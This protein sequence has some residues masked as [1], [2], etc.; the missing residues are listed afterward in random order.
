MLRIT[1]AEERETSV[2]RVRAEGR[3]VSDWVEVLERECQM[4]LEQ[5][6]WVEID[7]SGVT[8]IDGRGVEMLRRLR[9]GRFGIVN[10]SPFLED[11]LSGRGDR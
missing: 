1:R 7:L 8:F 11:L 6:Q 5:A 2:I 4:S 10:C 3:V 9:T